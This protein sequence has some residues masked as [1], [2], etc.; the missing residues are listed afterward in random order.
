MLL[1]ALLVTIMAW[2]AAAAEGKRVAFVVGIGT[3]NNLSSDKQLNNAVND[4][5]GV[6]AKLSEIGFRVTKA[7]NL[8]RSAF[9]EKW[10][11]VLDGL[12]RDDT[13][14][15]YFSGH[16][17]QVGGQNYLL[18]RDI[19]YIEYGRDEQ[20]KREAISLNELLADLSTGDRPHPQ[21][22]VVILDACR[23]N[24]LIPPGYKNAST[25]GGLAGLPESDGMFVMYAAASNRTALD[26]LSPSDNAK[27]S[28]F[29]R[30]LLPLIGRTDLSIQELS[31]ELKDQVWKLAKSVGREQRPTYYDGIVGRFCLPGCMAKSDAVGFKEN[32]TASVRPALPK[33]LTGKDG[34]PMVFIPAGS[35]LMGSTKD[36]VVSAMI[37]CVNEM[38]MGTQYCVRRYE[39]E[40]PQHD[41]QNDAFYLD[42]YEVTNRVF[43]LFVE[44]TGHQT[45]AEQEGSAG[46]NVDGKGWVDVKGASWRKPEAGATVFDSNRSEHPVV[47]VSWVDAQAYCRWAGK[48]LP[49]E[50]EFEYAT[51][52]GTET[53][54]WWGNGS[55]GSRRVAN[56]ADESLKRQYSDWPWPTM[57]SYDDGYIRTAPVGLYETNPWGLYDISGNVSEWTADWYYETYYKNSP[58]RNPKGPSGGQ[59][60]VVRGGSWDSGPV[61]GRSAYRNMLTPSHRSVNIGFRCA[62]DAV[63]PAMSEEV[64][65]KD[66]PNVAETFRAA[67]AYQCSAKPITQLK[68]K[69]EVFV[70]QWRAA[71]ERMKAERNIHDLQNLFEI[72]GRIPVG[73]TGEQLVA[74]A[75][76]TVDCLAASGHVETESSA[77][78]GHY[79]GVQFDNILMKFKK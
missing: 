51:R 28:V 24:P 18:P 9:N 75:R 14:V 35:F 59:Y 58:E 55:P 13:F 56:I 48:R 25:A 43:Q 53:K 15:L 36:E 78:P 74:E 50:A 10:Q 8:T 34:A 62:Q 71:I 47:A 72:W 76:Y 57:T 1:A 17:V 69:A 45:T 19:P 40:F 23:D 11:N 70:P 65:G 52:A 30:T 7:P 46:S 60:R 4:A 20:L 64:A 31:N 68:R 79:W 63:N 29:T 33:E 3:Y 67:T 26:R 6:S 61:T 27:Y 22:S 21:S 42:Q 5:E 16:G 77:K 2:P 38:H 49:S 37:A 66:V 39:D 32:L 44:Q 12:T 41:V 73:L 54:Y